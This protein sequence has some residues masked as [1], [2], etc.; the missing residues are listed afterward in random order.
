MSS[1]IVGSHLVL[2]NFSKSAAAVRS[3]DVGCRCSSMVR[4][5]RNNQ[6]SMSRAW[7]Y[8]TVGITELMNFK[9]IIK[10]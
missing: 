3:D 6:I 8:L 10:A 5:F 9:K 7:S 1:L 4:Y 2:L